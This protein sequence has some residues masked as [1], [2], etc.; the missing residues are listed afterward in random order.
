MNCCVPT[1][2]KSE[3]LGLQ[4]P[5]SLFVCET[6]SLNER[7]EQRFTLGRAVEENQLPWGIKKVRANI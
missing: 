7:L 4:R 3:Y 1:K 6:S 5:G 2:G